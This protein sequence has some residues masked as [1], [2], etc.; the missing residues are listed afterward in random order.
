[1][2]Q[3]I[4]NLYKFEELSTEAQQKAIEKFSDA[5]VGYNWWENV[6]DDAKEIGLRIDGFDLDRGRCVDGSLLFAANDVAQKILNNHGDQ[7]ETHKTANDF[8]NE[9]QP[10]SCDYMNEDSENYESR[11][12]EDKLMEIEQQF[13]RDLLEDY[14]IMLQHEYEYLTSEE[15]IKE[16]IINNE[17]EFTEEGKLS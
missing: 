1:M 11:D 6:Y 9:W 15:Y 7:C 12:I 5:G 2:R 8:M 3:K 13:E 10:I 14:L 16:F 4:I 17:Y